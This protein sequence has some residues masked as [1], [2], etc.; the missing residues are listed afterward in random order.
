MSDISKYYLNKIILITG[1]TGFIGRNIV[2]ELLNYD[3]KQIIIFD[4]TLK[5]SWESNK[6]LYIQGN[7]LT[8]LYKLNDYNFDIVFHQAA[9]VDTTD[10]NEDLMIN[11]NYISF[12]ELIKLC[13]KKLAKLIY[14]SSAATYGNSPV[15]NI[16]GINELPLNIYGKSKLMMDNYIR[17]NIDK[18]S[19]TIIG[20]RYFNVYGN[21]E[22]HKNKMKSMICQMIDNIKINNNVNLFEFGQQKRDFIYIKDIVMCNL[23]AGLSTTSDI[24]N[25]GYGKSVD[26]NTI[27]SIISSY[28]ISTSKI[29]YIKNTYDFFQN[30]TLSDIK[31]T[32]NNLLFVPLYDIEKGIKDYLSNI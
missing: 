2:N 25:C 8:D 20:L 24:Y 28:V 1:G 10:M 17:N 27:F 18:I 29:N 26:F 19:I 30:E 14:A 9:N 6:I 7:L 22:N 31:S 13:E 4:R 12:I 23:L 21:G 16:V 5:Y 15:P 32:N 3:I 11:T